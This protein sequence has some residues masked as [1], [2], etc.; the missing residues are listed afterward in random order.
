MA[1]DMAWSEG[2]V[3]VRRRERCAGRRRQERFRYGMRWSEAVSNHGTTGQGSLTL[4]RDHGWIHT[5]LSG[6]GIESSGNS[7]GVGAGERRC[8]AKGWVSDSSVTCKAGS[9]LG[10]GIRAV[11]TVWGAGGTGTE[12]VSFDDAGGAGTK[13]YA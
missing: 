11:V 8:E 1:G 6:T 13:S 5:L 12:G 9:G 10:R 3:G 4:D 2:G 7:V